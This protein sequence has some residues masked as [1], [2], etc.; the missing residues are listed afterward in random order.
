MGRMDTSE[1]PPV[2]R[3][4]S[5]SPLKGGSVMFCISHPKPL[6]WKLMAK[7]RINYKNLNVE[8]RTSNIEH[9]K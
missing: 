2:E 5:G 1:T 7:H 3:E 4:A 8:H 6:G 9:R